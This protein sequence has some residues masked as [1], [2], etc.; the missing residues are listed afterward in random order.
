VPLPRQISNAV[1]ALATAAPLATRW[2]ERLLVAADPPL[3]VAQY[4]ALQAISRGSVT[5]AELARG[6]GV[7]GAAVSQLVA[8]LQN[9]GW[10]ERE[11]D[12]GDRRRHGLALTELGAAVLRSASVSLRA[13]IGPL[14][15]ELPKPEVD[16]LGRLLVRLEVALGGAAPPR[17]PPP[18]PP[19]EAR[20]PGRR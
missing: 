12:P 14:L 20:R 10:I 16:A 4:L 15:A 13:G 19:P 5:G 8:G 2:I 6:A 7:S 9:A 11:L 1:D 3:T 18:P 17:R